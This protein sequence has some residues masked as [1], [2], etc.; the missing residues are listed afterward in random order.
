MIRGYIHLYT[1]TAKAKQ[2]QLWAW[3]SELLEQVK[4]FLL[5]NLLRACIMPN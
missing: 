5:P 2:Q 4:R 1:G 3:L